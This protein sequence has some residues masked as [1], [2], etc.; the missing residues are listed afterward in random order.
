MQPVLPRV[1]PQGL[2][3]MLDFIG[4]AFYRYGIYAGRRVFFSQNF[5]AYIQLRYVRGFFK[6]GETIEKNVLFVII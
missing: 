1:K 2:Y 3:F 5:V 6:M 4:I